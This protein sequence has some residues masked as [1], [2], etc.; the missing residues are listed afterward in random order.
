MSSNVLF[1]GGSVVEWLGRRIHDLVIYSWD[2]WPSLAGKLSWELVGV[3]PGK[4]PL[5]G[6]R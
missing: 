5:P 2:R 6:G 1:N 3:M 4:L